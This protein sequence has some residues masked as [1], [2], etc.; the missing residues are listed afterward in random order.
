MGLLTDFVSGAAQG[1]QQGVINWMEFDNRMQLMAKHIEMQ[2]AQNRAD[3]TWEA[4]ESQRRL[5]E[6]NKRVSTRADEIANSRTMK[7]NADLDKTASEYSDLLAKGDMTQ[8]Q[9]DAATK[10]LQG[11]RGL[12]E[13]VRSPTTKERLVA[14]AE[15]TGRGLDHL[16]NLEASEENHAASRAHQN[17]VLAETAGYHKE[18]LRQGDERIQGAKTAAGARAMGDSEKNITRSRERVLREKFEFKDTMTGDKQENVAAQKVATDLFDRITDSGESASVAQS[19]SIMAARSG[20][21][22]AMTVIRADPKRAAD[23]EALTK[24]GAKKW[25]DEQAKARSEKPAPAA[26]ETPAPDKPAPAAKSEPPAAA[27]ESGKG[28]SSAISLLSLRTDEKLRDLMSTNDSDSDI[29]KAAEAE[30]ARRAE[31]QA[32]RNKFFGKS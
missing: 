14:Q 8:E 30:L 9:Y 24:E 26:Q 13:S 25:W 3:K 31:V 7:N 28:R 4:D 2:S 20:H 11:N 27:P 23:I 21:D 19:K 10:G 12:L 15:I 1:A 6:Q 16:A 5:D 18:L 29:Y 17:A 32:K 22:Y